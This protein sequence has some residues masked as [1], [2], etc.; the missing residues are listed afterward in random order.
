[1]KDVL[2]EERMTM[3]T[4]V[5]GATCTSLNDILYSAVPCH[6]DSY[7]SIARKKTA[8]ILKSEVHGS[9]TGADFVGLEG[10]SPQYFDS[11]G[12]IQP[13]EVPNNVINT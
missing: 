7:K 6:E 10:S 5:D 1:M 13:H 8:S 11:L 2:L 9:I 12:L 3:Q 4:A